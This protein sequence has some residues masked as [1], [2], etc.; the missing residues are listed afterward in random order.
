L[1]ILR[2]GWTQ[3][4][5]HG[6]QVEGML[7]GLCW[8]S[9]HLSRGPST[10]GVTLLPPL[11]LPNLARA[12]RGVPSSTEGMGRDKYHAQAKGGQALSGT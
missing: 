2:L 8:G 9:A 11:S 12:S 6:R 4:T 1:K 3:S 5:I 10:F 7:P